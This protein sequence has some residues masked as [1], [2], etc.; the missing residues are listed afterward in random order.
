M[1]VVFSLTSLRVSVLELL[2]LAHSHITSL[3]ITLVFGFTISSFK[4]FSLLF[5][6]L[7][8]TLSCFSSDLKIFLAFRFNFSVGAVTVPLS[9][10]RGCPRDWQAHTQLTRKE[11]FTSLWEMWRPYKPIGHTFPSPFI[12]CFCILSPHAT[13]GPC[14]GLWDRVK[15]G[16]FSPAPCSS[17][18]TDPS[19]A[20]RGSAL[21][22]MGGDQSGDSLA[23]TPGG[24]EGRRRPTRQLC[25]LSRNP[26][27]PSIRAGPGSPR[28]AQRPSGVRGLY[29]LKPSVCKDRVSGPLDSS[30]KASFSLESRSSHCRAVSMCA[31]P[32]SERRDPLPLLGT[33]RGR[34]RSPPLGLLL[35]GRRAEWGLRGPL[36][37]QLHAP[38]ASRRSKIPR[39]PPQ[40]QH[41]RIK[42]ISYSSS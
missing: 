36:L 9:W 41:S 16:E 28:G 15:A 31:P 34:S 19:T 7:L 37:A 8:F 21:R 5:L 17:P 27:T 30:N 18:T 32:W 39:A 22:V 1:A 4:M 13:P 14:R 2:C 3:L 29:R 26:P 11:D 6:V 12:L 20:I 40:T 10:L 25:I 24:S 35:I 42:T 33:G 23:V 38:L